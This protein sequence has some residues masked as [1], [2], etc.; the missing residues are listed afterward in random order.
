[1]IEVE[2]K[3]DMC[4][5]ARERY[6][7][8]FPRRIRQEMPKALGQD[9]RRFIASPPL[10]TDTHIPD[11]GIIIP[12]NRA[13]NPTMCSGEAVRR[14]LSF[15]RFNPPFALSARTPCETREKNQIL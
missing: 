4:I 15:P 2:R 14:K 7:T 1:M 11:V 12:P 13:Y 9:K 6:V 8:G 5:N 10:S 3:R